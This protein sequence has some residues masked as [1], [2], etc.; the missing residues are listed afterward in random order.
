MATVKAT[1]EGIN[2]I[3]TYD[4]EGR[5]RMSPC[6]SI[7]KD[8]AL[9][10]FSP[11]CVTFLPLLLSVCLRLSLDSFPSAPPEA[12]QPPPLFSVTCATRSFSLSLSRSLR[13]TAAPVKHELSL[14]VFFFI[15]SA[16]V[17]SLSLIS[18]PRPRTHT[19]THAHFGACLCPSLVFALPS[20]GDGA[21][22]FTV[23]SPSIIFFVC[24]VFAS[25]RAPVCST[26]RSGS[27]PTLRRGVARCHH[28]RP[29]HGCKPSSQ[30]TGNCAVS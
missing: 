23:C 9:P 19:H 2:W 12:M 30:R 27:L 21:V 11:F 14:L 16:F 29:T 5:V 28:R 4:V 17:W 6:F 3:Q 13:S 20:F 22:S 24:F 18:C 1:A 25:F 10:P 26:A 8:R 15:P 7:I